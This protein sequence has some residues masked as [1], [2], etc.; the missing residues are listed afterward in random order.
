MYC[1]G[2]A[3]SSAGP[4]L[5]KQIAVPCSGGQRATDQFPSNHRPALG[6]RRH[7]QERDSYGSHGQPSTSS[8]NST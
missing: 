8:R 4:R 3:T 1:N 2:V 5:A 7:A 6:A